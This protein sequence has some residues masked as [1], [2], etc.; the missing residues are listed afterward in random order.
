MTNPTCTSTAEIH[1]YQT[2]INTH[3]SITNK[4]VIIEKKIT[5]TSIF[6]LN[7]NK[8]IKNN[9]KKI[10]IQGTNKQTNKQDIQK[11]K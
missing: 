4:K 9:N 11:Q 1:K 10:D 6:F 8:N 5:T 7:E 3:S 2:R